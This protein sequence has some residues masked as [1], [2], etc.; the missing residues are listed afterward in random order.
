M[1]ETIAELNEA[2]E[3][4]ATAQRRIHDLELQLKNITTEFQEQIKSVAHNAQS[5]SSSENV[6]LKGT[7]DELNKQVEDLRDKN[8][9]P[10]QTSNDNDSSTRN[11]GVT[12]NIDQLKKKFSAEREQWAKERRRLDSKIRHLT[13][14]IGTHKKWDM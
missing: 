5:N 6:K 10:C 8:I 14:Q 1:S 11:A 7:I 2:K 9:V 13:K 3:H 12:N 4:Y